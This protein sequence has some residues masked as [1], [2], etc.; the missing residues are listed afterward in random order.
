MSIANT[1]TPPTSAVSGY[2]GAAAL[3]M[4]GAKEAEQTTG[5]GN[6]GDEESALPPAGRQ[7]VA[8]TGKAAGAPA[9]AA[10]VAQL[11][12]AINR[13]NALMSQ[14]NGI[15]LLGRLVIEATN[16]GYQSERLVSQLEAKSAEIEFLNQA[17]KMSDAS[18]KMLTSAIVTATLSFVSGGIQ[19]AGGASGLRSA[20]KAASGAGKV[21]KAA[22][23]TD[24]AAAASNNVAASP[25]PTVAENAVAASNNV[26]A[27]PAQTATD[28]AA[29]AANNVAADA[30][31]TAASEAAAQKA[32]SLQSVLAGV[33][34]AIDGSGMLTKGILDSDVKRDEAQG[35]VYAAAAQRHNATREQESAVVQALTAT[36]LSLL[37][38]IKEVQEAE[39]DAMRAITARG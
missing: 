32:R 17:D 19:I 18:S 14:S 5:K 13:L 10:D 12:E 4:T 3:S 26:V 33:T 2:N 6:A 21:D 9:T 22:D 27:N 25:A 16:A 28:R 39:V 30:V 34:G 8:A 35:A 31:Q 23:I 7:R 37:S 20:S 36:L 15:D 11:E 24:K 1:Q 38:G 29:A